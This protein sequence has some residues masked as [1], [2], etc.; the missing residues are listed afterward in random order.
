MDTRHVT[1]HHNEVSRWRGIE[2]ISH[3]HWNSSI[4]TRERQDC[5]RA[6]TAAL[7]TIILC[8]LVPVVSNYYTTYLIVCVFFLQAMSLL[9]SRVL[10][11]STIN[12]SHLHYAT[13]L[14]NAIDSLALLCFKGCG[15][16]CSVPLLWLMRS[17]GRRV[18]VPG[19]FFFTKWS[20]P[21]HL[22]FRVLV[23]A[24]SKQ[25]GFRIHTCSL[26]CKEMGGLN[27]ARCDMESSKSP[28]FRVVGQ[29]G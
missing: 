25:K 29:R 5:S 15:F 8:C 26:P 6:A 23:K 20:P 3:S 1:E 21:I 14:M 13:P 27:N 12:W 11:P 18:C 4:L 16:Y 28:C 7:L 19:D 2:F 22:L 24:W 9:V 17:L 10:T